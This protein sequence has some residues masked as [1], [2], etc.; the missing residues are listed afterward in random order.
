M[1][2]QPHVSAH[3]AQCS[4]PALR[5]DFWHPGAVFNTSV[6]EGSGVSNVL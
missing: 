4:R 1:F 6:L 2:D 3:G 5:V